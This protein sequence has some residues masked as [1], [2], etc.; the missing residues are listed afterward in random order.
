M[1]DKDGKK[2]DKIEKIARSF[3]GSCIKHRRLDGKTMVN[4]FRRLM[5]MLGIDITSIKPKSSQG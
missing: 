5:S 1:K 3:S 4:D 2:D